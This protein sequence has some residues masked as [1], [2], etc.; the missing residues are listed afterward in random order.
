MIK[1]LFNGVIMKNKTLTNQRMVMV[2]LKA[3]ERNKSFLAK[4]IG[5]TP[6]I[7]TRFV[8]GKKVSAK[9]LIRLAMLTKLPL[10]IDCPFCGKTH[11]NRLCKGM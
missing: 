8:Q 1:G 11:T 10:V 2:W 9:I 4:H 6:A 3:N 7:I 5:V